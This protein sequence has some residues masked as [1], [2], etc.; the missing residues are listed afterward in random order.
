MFVFGNGE[1]RKNID[2][3]NIKIP[4]IGCNA[5]HRDFQVNHLICVDR[6]MVNEAIRVNYNKKC[7]IYTRRDW[8]ASYRLNQNVHQVPELP[9]TGNTKPD[10]PFHWGSGPYAIL[11]AATL[12]DKIK[13]AGFDLYSKDKKI[14]N[15]Y[16]GTENYETADKKAV[17]PRF[18]IYQIGKVFEYFPN[19]QFTVYTEESWNQPDSWKKDNV[20]LDNISNI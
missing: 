15:L 6:R 12:S 5:L 10:D 13:I 4:K 9:Y 14:N 16:K 3:S 18:W 17:D 8:W 11:L 1:S 7:K 2:I 19:K 20:M